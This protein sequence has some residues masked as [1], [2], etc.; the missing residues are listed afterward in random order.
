MESKFTLKGDIMDKIPLSKIKTQ[1]IYL[2]KGNYEGVDY[3][4]IHVMLDNGIKLKQKL[5]LF[6]FNTLM[7]NN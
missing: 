2:I 1:E 6:E 5:T 3:Y 4:Q 7:A